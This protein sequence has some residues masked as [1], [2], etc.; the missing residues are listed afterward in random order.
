[1][2]Y[3]LWGPAETQWPDL[4]KSYIC[5]LLFPLGFSNVSYIV[6]ASEIS[7][8]HSPAGKVW[9]LQ[10]HGRRCMDVY[11]LISQRTIYHSTLAVIDIFSGAQSRAEQH[12]VLDSHKELV[13]PLLWVWKMK[14]QGVGYQFYSVVCGTNI[15]CWQV[16][17]GCDDNL[18]HHTHKVF[19]L[20]LN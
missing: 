19:L 11:I 3:S 1:M 13:Q 4:R 8:F 17:F 9:Q 6:G 15:P 18:F 7:H 14:G 12:L 5:I 2:L 20:M 16:W 10:V